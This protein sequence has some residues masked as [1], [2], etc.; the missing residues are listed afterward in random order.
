MTVLILAD[1]PARYLGGSIETFALPYAAFIVIAGAL[2]FV[3]RRPQSVPRMRYLQSAHQTATG[4]REPGTVGT[5][6]VHS[7]GAAGPAAAEA[8]AGK[9]AEETE[10]RA[11]EAKGAHGETG[12]PAGKAEGDA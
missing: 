3:L 11:D 10:G 6:R 8:E 9:P 7:A 5:V 12:G 2:Y 1:G 4:T